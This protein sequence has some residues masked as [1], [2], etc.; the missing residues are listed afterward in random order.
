MLY[1]MSRDGTNVRM[2]FEST[3]IRVFFNY[4]YS[5]SYS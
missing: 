2:V 4:S 5:Y 1:I 3:N